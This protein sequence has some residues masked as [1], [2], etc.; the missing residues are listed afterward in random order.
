MIVEQLGRDL[1][2]MMGPENREP[3]YDAE[4]LKKLGGMVEELL[5]ET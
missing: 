2:M 5:V 3:A 1:K 4:D